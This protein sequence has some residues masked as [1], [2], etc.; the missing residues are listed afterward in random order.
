MGVGG[1]GGM[2]EERRGRGWYVSAG[3]LVTEKGSGCK[4]VFFARQKATNVDRRLLLP[5][6]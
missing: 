4:H 3:L 2:Q 6:P 1:G 5:P